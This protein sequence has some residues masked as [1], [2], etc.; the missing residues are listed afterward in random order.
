MGTEIAED[1]E[2]FILALAD[3]IIELSDYRT[4]LNEYLSNRM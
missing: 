1:D 3:Q 2:K 4:S